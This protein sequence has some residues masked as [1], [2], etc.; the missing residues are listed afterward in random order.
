MSAFPEVD[1]FAILCTTGCTC[2]RS[3]NHWF[4]GFTSAEVAI[5]YAQSLWNSKHICSQYSAHGHYGVYQFKGE[6]LPDGRIIVQD[7][8]ISA[9][10][11]NE[12]R[13]EDALCS[14]LGT[15][16]KDL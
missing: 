10:E 8:V 16:I 2:C 1:T 13:G 12:E 3:E 4:T 14:Y 6:L 9:E 11:G 5:A 7:R 15:N